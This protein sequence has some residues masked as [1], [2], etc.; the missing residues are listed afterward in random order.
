MW[1][2]RVIITCLKSLHLQDFQKTLY[3]LNYS[4]TKASKYDIICRTFMQ[5]TEATRRDI[6]DIFTIEQIHWAGRLEDSEFLARLFNL[7]VLPSTDHRFR[8]ARDDIWQHRINNH[9]W[10]DNWVFNDPR[11]NLLRCDDELFLRFLCETIHPV[12]RSNVEEVER[13]RQAYNL[14]LTSDGYE[15]IAKTQMA[16]RAIYTARRIQLSINSNVKSLKQKF[17]GTDT[18]YVLGQLTRMESSIDNDPSLAIGTAKEL[19]ETICKTIL[20]ERGQAIDGTP[21]LPKLVKQTVKE[22]KLTP[23]DIPDKSKAANSIKLIFS[24]LATITNGIAELR[25]NYG[26]GHGKDSKTKGLGSR[27]AKL[28]VGAASTLAIFLIET[29]NERK[30]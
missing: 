30:T 28:A 5:I 12:V 25:N 3:D 27:H 16:G 2:A 17:D 23:D 7:E 15:I 4:I 26:T 10:F 21:D 14:L 8:N 20:S 29:H 1:L 24:N 19:I 13:L 6:T 22:L 9:D 11:F 18:N